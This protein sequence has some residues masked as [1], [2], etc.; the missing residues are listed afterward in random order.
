MLCIN[1]IQKLVDY[2]IKIQ[3]QKEIL[4]FYKENV[5]KNTLRYE[6]EKTYEN[7]TNKEY[8]KITLEELFPSFPYSLKQEA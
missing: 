1:L 7:Q 5:K 6:E 2:T 4:T 3:I 8:V